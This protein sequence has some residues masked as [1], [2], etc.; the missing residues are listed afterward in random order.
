MVADLYTAVCD[1]AFGLGPIRIIFRIPEIEQI[2]LGHQIMDR[3]QDADP[4]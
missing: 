3:V 2:L 1:L 4:A